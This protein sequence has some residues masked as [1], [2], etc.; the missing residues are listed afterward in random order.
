MLKR[1]D[2]SEATLRDQQEFEAYMSAAAAKEGIE[3]FDAVEALVE[4]G[5]D[6]DLR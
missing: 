5:Y 1:P 3:A 6:I 4:L 2:D